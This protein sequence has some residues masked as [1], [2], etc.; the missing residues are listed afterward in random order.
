VV[1]GLEEEGTWRR[2]DAL[3]PREYTRLLAAGHRRRALFTDISRRFEE[4][5]F[6]ARTATDD[7]RSAVMARLK[8]LGCLPA[9]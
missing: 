7:D 9:A 8:E 4:V 2:D 3:T 6:A 5:W 1:A